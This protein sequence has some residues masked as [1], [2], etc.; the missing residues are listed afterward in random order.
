M[1][2]LKRL[3]CMSRGLPGIATLREAVHL[4]D[5]TRAG[6]F[7]ELTQSRLDDAYRFAA[8]I[9]GQDFEAE[10]AVHDAAVRAWMRWR[11]LRNPSAFDSWF[12]R[13][14]VNECRERL[15]RRARLPRTR[16]IDVDPVAPD[17]AQ[18]AAQRDLIAEAIERLS[19]DHKIAI[20]LRYL[21]DLPTEEIARRTASRS[22]TVRSR[23]HYALREMRAACEALDR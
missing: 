2:S 17:H 23:L 20:V 18:R 16:V 4:G 19:P 3:S 6:L 11:D 14:L 1:G 22:G 15:R 13:I 7:D 9:L 12:N 21:E 5:E 8:S 10:D